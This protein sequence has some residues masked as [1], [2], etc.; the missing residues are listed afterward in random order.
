MKNTLKANQEHILELG[1]Y[2][3]GQL[4][5]YLEDKNGFPIAELSIM[6]KTLDLKEN[7]FIYKDY[8]EHNDFSQELLNL[9]IIKPTNKF[10]IVGSHLC[11]IC[12]IPN[13]V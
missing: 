12:Y 10:V 5:V 11:P 9:D 1:K 6:E 4:A 8:S 3:N 13:Y 7:E 2:P